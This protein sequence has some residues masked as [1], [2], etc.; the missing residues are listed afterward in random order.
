[1]DARERAKQEAARLLALRRAQLDD[2][3]EEL[4]R[5][6][7]AV[8]RCHRQQRDAGTRVL[9]SLQDVAAQEQ[10]CTETKELN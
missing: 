9:K 5:R 1:M 6:K 10:L 2:A 4:S 8:E 7:E 3:E